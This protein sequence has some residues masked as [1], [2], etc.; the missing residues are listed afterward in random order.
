MKFEVKSNNFY[1][2]IN[3]A[4]KARSKS[5]LNPELNNIF[6]ELKDNI[7]TCRATNLEITC[8][9][10]IIVKGIMN[11]KCVLN[12]NVITKISQ[13]FSNINTN[14]VCELIDNN[15]N[16]FYLKNKISL[17]TIT[18]EDFP[19]LP[20]VGNFLFN[21]NLKTFINLIKNVS[22]SA[23]KTEIK[24][25]ISSIYLYSK[26]N[27]LYCVATDSFRLSEKKIDFKIEG[28]NDINILIS[29][30]NI[31]DIIFILDEINTKENENYDLNIYKNENIL[32]LEI[33][34]TIIAIGS[35]NGNFPDYK[36]LFPKEYLIKIKLNKDELKNI[37]NLSN[38]F[39][40]NY[41]YIDIDIDI[42]NKILKTKS[43]NDSIGEV[44]KEIQILDTES[45]E[46]N[47]KVSYN[48]NF[49]LEGLNHIDDNEI[50]LSF[51]TSNRPL[52]L[53]GVNDLSYT[54]LLMSLNR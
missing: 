10:S 2:L 3:I 16:I 19:N 38:V 26:D 39:A 12:G 36:Q 41:S 8:E 18:F 28:E 5:N 47:I 29:Q 45:K 20:K 13:S 7:L 30:K 1:K 48:S 15:F 17:K 9:K 23:A 11:G 21:I 40:N 6:F 31:T 51:T 42:K 50:E 14:I 25:E 54:Y 49:F 43:K 52:F 27:I 53:R 33:D 37:L 24:P 34:N 4:D 46:E 35:I 44:E 22:F 32:S